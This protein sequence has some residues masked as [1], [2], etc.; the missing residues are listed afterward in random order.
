MCLPQRSLGH[1][2][3]LQNRDAPQGDPNSDVS[4]PC[5]PGSMIRG[6]LI[7]RYLQDRGLRSTDDILDTSKFP[8]VQRLF[9]DGSTRYLNAYLYSNDQEKRT[10]PVP[11][12]WL[13]KKGDEAT[14]SKDLSIYDFSW[15]QPNQDISYKSLNE[16]F[17]TVDD[18]DVVLYKEKRR[19]NIHNMRDRKKGRG[20]D[21]NG[22]VFR[23]DALD[24]GQTFQGVILCDNADDVA[25]IKPLLELKDIFLGGSRKAGYGHTTIEIIPNKEDINWHEVETP[26]EDREDREL[27][28]ITLLSD[29]ILRDRCGQYVAMPPIQLITDEGEREIDPLTQLLEQLLDVK[30]E[31][32]SSFTSSIVVGGFNRKWGLPLPQVPALAAGSVFIFNY[33]GELNIDRIRTLENQGIGER[34]VDGF[35]RLAVNWL[36]EYPKFTASL[37]KS[38]VDLTHQPNLTPNSEDSQIAAKMAK[39]LLEQKLDKQLLD[40]VHRWTLEPNKLSNSQLSRLI[41]MARQ[42]LTEESKSPVINLVENLPKNANSQFEDTKVNGKPFKKQICEWLNEPNSWID[43]QHLE[44]NIAGESVTSNLVEKLKLDYTLRLIIAIAKKANKENKNE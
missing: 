41:I 36:E 34:R 4:F 2:R 19:I 37:L 1:L 38:E 43:S 21:D 9:F 29:L 33:Q 12:S 27:L 25:K 5:I 13:K 26:L 18:E 44:I 6:V 10:L 24:A 15:E 31:P 3:L 30:L 23:Y 20:T 39:R 16:S 42:A 14:D 32:Q 28:R 17:C 40:K 22:A 35:G 11:R 7:S 8:E